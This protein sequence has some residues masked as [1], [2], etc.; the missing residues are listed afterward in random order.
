MEVLQVRAEFAVI[1]L[2]LCGRVAG[3]Y[4]GTRAA[5][6]IRE[7]VIR[8]AVTVLLVLAAT[9]ELSDVIGFE[10]GTQPWHLA[11]L[12]G[13]YGEMAM[14]AAGLIVGL[15]SGLTGLGGGIFL[16]PLLIVA[17]GLSQRAAQG[18]SLIVIIPT[19]LVGAA[20][21]IQRH[22]VDFRSAQMMALTGAPAALIGAMLA[23]FVPTRLL[24][25]LFAG[26]LITAAIRIAP[27]PRGDRPGMGLG[28][29]SLKPATAV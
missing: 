22:N 1:A 16:V 12:N 28:D 14:I 20:Q 6:A 15:L 23:V 24:I 7:P 27:W 4:V 9:K 29:A 11:P 19:A 3:V 2:I 26:F 13:T 18:I 25:A 8:V 10:V 5:H 21:Y 17:F